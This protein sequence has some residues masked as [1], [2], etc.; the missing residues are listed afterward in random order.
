MQTEEPATEK[1]LAEQARHAVPLAYVFSGQVCEQ[2]LIK[3]DPKEIVV[4]PAVQDVHVL[5]LDPVAME[6]E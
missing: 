5:K 1:E 4:V 3:V 2:S 6:E